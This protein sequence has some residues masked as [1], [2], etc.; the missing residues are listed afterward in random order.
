MATEGV[1]AVRD[2]EGTEM[3]QLRDR[4]LAEIE[5]LR[6]RLHEYCAQM[7]G[8]ALDAEDVVQDVLAKAWFKLPIFDRSRPLEPWLF[9]IAQRQC[10][11][12]IRR[13]KR[14]RETTDV[15]DGI[16]PSPEGR[17][18]STADVDRGLRRLM[19]ALPPKERAAVILKDVFDYQLHEVAEVIGSTTQG[20]KAALHRGR[21]KLDDLRE[22][23][24]VQPQSLSEDEATILRLYVDRFNRRD[25][26]GV[27]EL[28]RADAHL[29]VLERFEGALAAAPY[30]SNYEAL[31]DRGIPWRMGL[32]LVDG[33]PAILRWGQDSSGVWEVR[34]AARVE[35]QDGRIDAIRDYSHIPYLLEGADVVALDV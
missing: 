4:F 3:D 1:L 34:S 28:A 27:L 16:S 33:V 15:V 26:D 23:P 29:E 14:R 13:V 7:L 17:A 12:A 30:F 24:A 9:R 22:Q 8:S 18:L 35:I 5:Q 11:D 19:S 25:W 31:V 6:P 20:V 2:S 32:G 10:L 21:R